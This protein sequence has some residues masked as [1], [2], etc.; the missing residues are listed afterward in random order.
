VAITVPDQSRLWSRRSV[1]RAQRW[2]IVAGTCGL[3]TSAAHA[4]PGVALDQ[5]RAPGS[6]LDGFAAARPDVGEHLRLE[7]RLSLDYAHDPLV[8]EAR[9]NSTQSERVRLVGDQLAAQLGVA[10]GVVERLLFF[11]SLPMNLV[12]EGTPLGSQPTATGFGAGDLGAG[13]RLL[14]LRGEPGALAIELGAT[15]PTGAGSSRGPAVAGDAS[16]TFVPSLLGEMTFGAL[17]VTTDIG[18]R[19]RKTVTLPG[20]DRFANQLSY[21]LALSLPFGPDVLRVQAEVFGSTLTADA[22]LRAS[23]PLEALLGLKLRPNDTLG[24]GLAGGMGLLRGYGSPD[25]RIIGQFAWHTLAASRAP[26]PEPLAQPSRPEPIVAPPPRAAAPAPEPAPVVLDPDR[27]GIPDA[28]DACP[29]LAGLDAL[30]GCPEYVSYAPASGLLTL[31]PAPTFLRGTAKLAPRSLVAL[32]SLATA[33]AAG[34]TQRVIIEVHLDPKTKG[35]LAQLSQERARAFAAWLVEHG[36]AATRLEAYGC[37]TSRPLAAARRDRGSS[38]RVEIYLVQPLPELGMPSTLNCV[39]APLAGVE[40]PSAARAAPAASSG[41]AARLV[42]VGIGAERI[43]AYGCGVRRA[44]ATARSSQV[45]TMAANNLP[46]EQKKN[47][48]IDLALL[49]P[50]LDSGVRSSEGCVSS[51]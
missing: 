48:R 23:S 24:F 50:T 41:V 36:V 14:L 49:D 44:R 8:Y 2:L 20:G 33:L 6:S 18:L 17:R 9:R 12:M 16:A 35:D 10:L 39:A 19:V 4:S 34:P 1:E 32:D 42:R 27:D 40:P 26:T 45:E 47:E 13:A 22:G 43:E 37:A 25:L 11:A 21:A 15:L 3:F 46:A 29:A 5:Y 28:D 51:E 31:T 30:R 7:A 38:E